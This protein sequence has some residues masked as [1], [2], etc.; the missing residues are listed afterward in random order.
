VLTDTGQPDGQPKTEAS[1]RLS[2][3]AA[4]NRN[5]H[6]IMS[7]MI[8]ESKMVRMIIFIHQYQ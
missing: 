1:H 5:C 4:A 2:L 7:D 3:A 8:N 6:H